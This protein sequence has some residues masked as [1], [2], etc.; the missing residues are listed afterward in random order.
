[1]ALV[2]PPPQTLMPPQF[3]DDPILRT[4][5]EERDR[6]LLQLWTR[7]GGATDAVAASSDSVETL[8]LIAGLN[9]RLGS[10]QFLTSDS[11]SFT[12]D[13]DTLFVDMIEA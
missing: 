2:N 13:S 10:E 1:M 8:S 6:V 12:V 9:E 3:R 4:Y 5:F 7:T 11:D